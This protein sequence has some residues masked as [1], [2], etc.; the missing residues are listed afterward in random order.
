LS[1]TTN[2]TSGT[3][4]TFN[5]TASTVVGQNIY[6]VGSHAALGNWNTGAAILLSSASYPK[7]SV[8]LSLPG[9]TVLEYKYIKK[10]GSGNV[11]WES[12]A[13]RST[14]TPASG[15]ATLNDTWK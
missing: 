3:T 2:T 5:E 11:T 8:T 12:G 9:S 7:W 6:L 15:A 13:N 14:T 10:D 4:I 1:V